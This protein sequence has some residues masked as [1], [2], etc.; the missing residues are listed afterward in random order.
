LLE[1]D[2]AG[3]LLDDLIIEGGTMP[4]DAQRMSGVVLRGAHATGADAS[5]VRVRGC[6]MRELFDGVSVSGRPDGA[7]AGVQ[8][9]DNQMERLFRGFQLSGTIRDVQIAGNRV[10]TAG[11]TGLQIE[12]LATESDRISMVNNTITRSGAGFRIWDQ[13]QSLKK[14]AVEFRNNL[15]FDLSQADI[16]AVIRGEPSDADKFAK[17]FRLGFNT[18]DLSGSEAAAALPVDSADLRLAADAAPDRKTLRP[19]ADSPLA[20]GGA[21]KDDATLPL[22]VGAVPP[23]GTPAWDWDKTWR[24]RMKKTH[25]GDA[26]SAG[27]KPASK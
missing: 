27:K 10:Q 3:V 23:K 16:L 15:L 18:R 25:R 2:V 17:D 6:T 20:T 21:G 7:S 26:E 4:S 19:A 12:N 14:G 13:S 9:L 22:Y 5:P 11:L 1:R 24:W 8:F